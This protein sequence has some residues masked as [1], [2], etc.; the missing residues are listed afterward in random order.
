MSE[1]DDIPGTYLFD[2]NRCH[3]GYHFNM[4][5]MSL[6]KPKNRQAF[7]TDEA[8]YIDNWPLT[9]LQRRVVLERDWLGM[10]KAGGNIYYTSKIAATDGYS[11]QYIAAVMSGLPEEEYRAMMMAGGRSVEGNRSKSETG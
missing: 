11:F 3:E 6:V 1:F 7:R 5:C 9:E 8:S 10:I 2:K 4:F